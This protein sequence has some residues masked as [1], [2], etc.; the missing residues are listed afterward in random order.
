MTTKLAFVGLLAAAA[1]AQASGFPSD[2][3]TRTATAKATAFRARGHIEGLYPGVRT[4]LRVR[5]RNT[6]RRP[7]TLTRLTAK[8]H[9]A[10][11]GCPAKSVKIKPF[12]RRR[13]IRGRATV[14]VKL[15]MRMKADAPDAC[16]GNRYRLTYS[17]RATI[18]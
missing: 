17:G 1:L 10:T 11:A 18:A 8:V 9:S 4:S 6:Q 3:G 16:Q 2:P 15:P 7:I 12:T 5:V 14:T 13:R